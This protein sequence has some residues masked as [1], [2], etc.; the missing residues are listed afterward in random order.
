MSDFKKIFDKLYNLE[1]LTV[2]ESSFIFNEIMSGKVPDIVIS[3][4][5]T[6][7]KIKGETF[8]EI[9][10]ATI[11]LRKKAEKINPPKNTVDT[12][13]TGGDMKGTLNISTA[14]A[15]VAASTGVKIA[16]H[17]NRSVSSSSGSADV[18]EKLGI[19]I[20]LDLNNIE[21]ILI[22]KNFCFMFAQLFHKAMKHVGP[23]RKTLGTRTIF[24]LLGPLSNPANTKKQLLGVFDKKWLNIHA[25]V[26]QKLGSEHV[27]VVH[28]FDGLDEISLSSNTYIT[29]LKDN[30]INEYI[31][32]PQDI[33]YS[34][35]NIEKI[36][37]GDSIYNAKEIIRM[38]DGENK[39]FQE[40]V[41]LNA[42]ATIYLSGI[43]K[44]IK[45]GTEISKNFI[46]SGKA[47]SYLKSLI[48]YSNS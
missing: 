3:S 12:C 5:L 35:I 24:N 17:G 36:K 8:N 43:G 19:K 37:G 15:L 44:D 40:I 20:D 30:K 26:L 31:F 42:G 23:V 25:K 9:L 4:F 34:M 7:L 14:S 29:E 48:Q 28:S 41:E 47:K 32:N 11:I 18:L 33:G 21:K 10:G 13:G 38:L 2:E 22:N 39:P 45:E 6:A 46:N 27:L 16:K 1:N